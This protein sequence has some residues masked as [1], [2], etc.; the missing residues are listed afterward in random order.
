MRLCGHGAAVSTAWYPIL[1]RACR[2][3]SS[4]A[5]IMSQLMH[6]W[7]HHVG[8]CYT[9]SHGCVDVTGN[10]TDASAVDSGPASFLV[11]AV[12][13]AQFSSPC[14]LLCWPAVERGGGTGLMWTH[15]VRGPWSTSA[16]FLGWSCGLVVSLQDSSPAH[17]F[18]CACLLALQGLPCGWP[19]TLRAPHCGW[20]PVP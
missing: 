14:G 11:T 1:G 3:V 19:A 10:C 8:T 4:G 7:T 18:G 13:L 9:T 5:S 17:V 6:N 12:G 20:Q 16:R 15:T 2:L